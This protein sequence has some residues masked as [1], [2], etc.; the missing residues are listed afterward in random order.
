MELNPNNPVVAEFRDQWHKL[1][2]ILMWKFRVNKVQITLEDIDRFMNDQRFGKNIVLDN[3][4][5]DPRRPLT[6]RLVNDDEAVRLARE[7]GGLP[8]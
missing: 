7:E 5:D 6:L 4:G 8:V 3:R 2:A 1:A